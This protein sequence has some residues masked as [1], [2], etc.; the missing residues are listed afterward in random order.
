MPAWADEFRIRDIEIQGLQRISPETVR[1]YLPVRRGE[2]ISS[3]KTSKIISALYKTGLF[4]NI[5]LARRDGVLV[6]K[7]IERPIIGYL[8][9]TGNSAI[10]SDRL[11][12]VM[13][14][15][16]VVE[17]RVYN[18]AVLEKIK[19]SL[20]NQYYQ[21]GYYNVQITVDAAEMSNNRIS[22]KITISEGV[23]AKIRGVHIIGSHVFSEAQLQ[24]QLTVSMPNLFSFITQSDRYSE[25]KL[26]E[27]LEKLRGFYMDHGYLKFNIKSAQAEITP[28]RKAIYIV[29]TVDEGVPYYIKGYK[30]SGD[31]I[32]PKAEIEKKITMKPGDK[33]SRQEIIDS[34]KA[35]TDIYGNDGY[36]FVSVTVDPQIDEAKKQVFLAFQ[37]T[38]GKKVYVRHLTFVDNHRTNDAALRREA[39]QFE[40]AP[41][42]TS[43]LEETKHRLSLL[44][45]MKDVQMSVKPVPETEDQVDVSYKVTEDNSAQASVTASY[46][47][48][49]RFGFGVGLNQKN[50]FGT[51]NNLGINFTQNRYEKY[52]SVAYSDPYYTLDGISRDVNLYV[53]RVNPAGANMAKAFTSNDMGATVTY[54]I[55]IGLEKNVLSRFYMGFGVED[56]LIHLTSQPTEQVTDFTNEHGRHFQ[57]AHIHTGITR[58]SR[59]KAIFPTMGNIEKAFGDLYAPLA[60]G[61]LKYFQF[62]FEGKWYYPLARGFIAAARASL[63]YGNS[64]D[65][66]NGYPFFKNY[67]T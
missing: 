55:P 23:V 33:F 35:I 65:G 63:G 31:L 67:Y 49:D 17:G 1:H 9:I 21:M 59:D 6:I 3:E 19:Q 10:S 46:S 14:D 27:S 58:D 47:M 18:P 42:T 62:N 40:S 38:P 4:E 7:L 22:V 32:L 12:S 13:K 20:L 41:A 56:T 25:E 11:D 15:L 39:T 45:F 60:D 64:F 2:E 48:V 57:Q 43:R 61:S 44:P 24:K 52:Y 53:S 54:G 36:L 50:F 66:I 29:I 26:E 34:E 28:D 8:K 51:G 5:T 16:D 37:I 30:L